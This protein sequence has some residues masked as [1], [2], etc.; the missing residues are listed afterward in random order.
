M[1]RDLER[2]MVLIAL[3]LVVIASGVD[4]LEDLREGNSWLDLL[5]DA[6]FSGF[7]AATLLY[8]WVQRP[9]A[10]KQRNK[11]LERAMRRSDDDLKIWKERASDLLQGLGQKIDEQ[12]NDWKLSVAEKEIA[13]LLIKGIPLKELA[14]LR[15]T[16]ER[17]VRQQA[18]KVYS[19]AN[20]DG[21]AELAAFFLEDL[22]LPT[23]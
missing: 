8:I 22:L 16:S 14:A 12:L 1:N 7:V 9:S 4:L 20:L 17:T 11:H 3:M 6:F 13:L 23:Q 19:K 21:R 5:I 15:G 10:T 2:P 18:S